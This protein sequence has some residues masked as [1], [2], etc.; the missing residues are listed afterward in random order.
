MNLATAQL[1]RWIGSL[2]VS[3]LT[4]AAEV[5]PHGSTAYAAIAGLLG[6]AGNLGIHVIPSIT[7]TGSAA[8]PETRP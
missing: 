1:M 8:P 4:I 3:G 5:L 6:I 7:Q 2:V